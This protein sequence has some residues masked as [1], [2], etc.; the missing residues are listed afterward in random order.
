MRIR[1]TRPQVGEV[2]GLDLSRFEV[3]AVYEVDSSVG[4]YLVTTRSAEPVA[5]DERAAPPVNYAHRKVAP[6]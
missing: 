3:G 6:A 2:N 5:S 4:T 1:I